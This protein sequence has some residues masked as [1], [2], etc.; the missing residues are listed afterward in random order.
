MLE[1]KWIPRGHA[2]SAAGVGK[3][4]GSH[5]LKD[6][7]QYTKENVESFFCN[8]K[9][10]VGREVSGAGD[11]VRKTSFVFSNLYKVDLFYPIYFSEGLTVT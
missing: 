4:G 3:I 10:N 7:Y 8:G 6:A 2:F 11:S 1:Y 9:K 5:S